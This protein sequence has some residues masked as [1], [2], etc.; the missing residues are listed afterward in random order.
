MSPLK[1]TFLIIGFLYIITMFWA[2]FSSLWSSVVVSA[3]GIL[4]SVAGTKL[5]DRADGL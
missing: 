1:L 3:F 4:I 2:A 5:A